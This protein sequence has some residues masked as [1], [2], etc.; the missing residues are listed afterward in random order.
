MTTAAGT[1]RPQGPKLARRALLVIVGLLL[2]WLV[3]GVTV[4][5]TLQARHSEATLKWWPWS[6]G[7]QANAAW[8]IVSKPAASPAEIGRASWMARNAL[9]R[10]P[11][12][13]AAVRT[14][15]VVAGLQNKVPLSERLMGAAER[16]SRRDLPTQLLLVQD[17]VGRN[18]IDAALVHYNRALTTSPASSE[19][20]L[21][22]LVGATSDPDIA[23]KLGAMLSG[24]PV[25]WQSFFEALAATGN[26]PAGMA[27]VARAARLRDNVAEEHD[28]L[29]SLIDRVSAL[30][31]YPEAFSI[32]S[33]AR[34]IKGRMPLL[35]D[36][37]FEAETSLPPV[38]WRLAS[39]PEAAGVREPRD[40]ARGNAL[41]L[42]GS[43]GEVAR[44][45]LILAPGSY[46]LTGRT[47]KVSG[48]HFSL[49]VIAVSCT[50]G[51]RQLDFRLPA[52][53]APS[54]FTAEF[55]VPADCAAQW[56][57]IAIRASSTSPDASTPWLD[58]LN[59]QRVG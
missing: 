57:T 5:G 36:G 12:N 58:D 7:A 14:L 1:G 16:L 28:L 45:L 48:D 15:A 4:Q 20:L 34:G 9:A 19:M 18:D 42:V 13:V 47:A 21:P 59:L 8:A 44:Q 2:L 3:L 35:R 52:G 23:G 55:V 29:V 40:G 27:I 50:T 37:N 38:D 39:E 17:S 43:V 10:E 53:D 24:R 30:K 41:S 6:A 51:K 25:W 26:A 31:A 32:F 22:V 46:R 33:S 56:L 54:A 49:P 11:V